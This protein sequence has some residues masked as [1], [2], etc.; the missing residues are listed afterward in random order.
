MDLASHPKQLIHKKSQNVHSAS[1]PR[2][3]PKKQEHLQ[4]T[5][6]TFSQCC[7]LVCHA[8]SMALGMAVLVGLS[9]CQLLSSPVQTVISQEV[10]CVCSL[11]G[12]GISGDELAS[13][14]KSVISN[15]RELEL[16]GNILRDSLCSVLSVG[17]GSPK[18]EKLRSVSDILFTK[19]LMVNKRFYI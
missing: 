17:L 16:S 13:A 12:W 19:F 1:Q 9:I 15:L 8:S 11:S 14:V 4:I 7:Q 2:T 10:L 18:L 6:S 3:S 5:A